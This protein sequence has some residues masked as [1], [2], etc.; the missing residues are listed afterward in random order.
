M[1]EVLRRRCERRS[2]E[3]QPAWRRH[4]HRCGK[5]A[6][7]AA[8]R[9]PG[10][11]FSCAFL[12]RRLDLSSMFGVDA[13]A[14]PHLRARSRTQDPPAPRTARR[15]AAPRAFPH[16]RAALRRRHPRPGVSP[17]ATL[18]TPARSTAGSLPSLTPRCRQLSTRYAPGSGTRSDGAVMP[19]VATPSRLR[20]PLGANRANQRPPQGTPNGTDPP[21]GSTPVFANEVKCASNF[22]YAL[23]EF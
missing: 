6:P 12:P 21:L 18:S 13:G 11:N 2:H 9:C 14:R 4:P 23:R 22:L 8:G 20:A 1:V 7:A 19:R 3:R 5:L 17:T 15:R 16:R 10:R